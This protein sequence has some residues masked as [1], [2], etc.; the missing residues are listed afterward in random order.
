MYKKPEKHSFQVFSENLKTNKFQKVM[1]MYGVEQYLVKWAVETLVD[2]FVNPAASAIDYVILDEDATVSQ[3]IEA[4]ETFSMFSQHR[5]I[6]VKNF[7]PLSSD[8]VRG[9]SKEEIQKLAEYVSNS[10][11]SA[12][13][14]FSAEEVKLTTI[15]ASAIKK[16]G[17]IYDFEKVDK[18]VFRSFAVK[19]FREAGAE[20][21]PSAL[22]HLIDATGYFNKESDYRLFHFA[23]DIQKIIAHAEGKQI[24]DEDI[25]RTVSG[26]M[27][28]FVFDMLDGISGNHKDKAFR[29][30]YNMLHSGTTP[31]S[32]IGSIV[33]QFELMLSVRQLRDDGYDLKAMHKKLGGSEYRIKKMI[34]YANRYSV[35]KLKKI[36]IS[37]Y[38]VDRNIKT[39]VLD[40]QTALELFI[41]QI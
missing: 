12:F 18:S 30:L 34:P 2:K 1:L 24:T 15:L 41:A 4:C 26:D 7:K 16:N 36:L 37:I 35:N 31:F 6:W 38:E 22:N 27:E 33:S 9:Y 28:T 8:S 23:N 10:N 19:R 3:I 32:I 13:L 40:S 25:E 29:I 14:V 11:D 20:I 39:G 5:V 17:Q 21:T